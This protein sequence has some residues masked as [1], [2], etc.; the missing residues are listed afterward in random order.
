MNGSIKARSGP[1]IQQSCQNQRQ[2]SDATLDPAVRALQKLLKNPIAFVPATSLT[3]KDEAR[4]LPVLCRRN[5]IRQN[6]SVPQRHQRPK[7]RVLTLV[8]WYYAA[9]MD[10]Q[11][12]DI[13]AIWHRQSA[14]P[15]PSRGLQNTQNLCYRNSVL[16]ALLHVPKFVNWL[17]QDHSSC[18]I[19]RCV[20]CSLRT[21]CFRYWDVPEDQQ[22]ITQA[23]RTSREAIGATR[24]KFR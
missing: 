8:S 15:T 19:A 14:G 16:Q 17:E 22:T 9:D 13:S 18:T 6:E 12:S 23:L 3:F 10:W 1:P 20:A 2:P 7:V 4:M 11:M 5:T 21:L 24:S